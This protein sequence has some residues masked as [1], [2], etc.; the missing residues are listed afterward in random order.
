MPFKSPKF[1]FYLWLTLA[2]KLLIIGLSLLSLLSFFALQ[3]LLPRGDEVVVYANGTEKLRLSLAQ[4]RTVT[5]QG[6]R[7]ATVIRIQ[8]GEARVIR[9]ACHHQICV[10]TAP[11]RRSG[12]IIVCIPNQ[13]LV[14]IEGEKPR[15]P[16]DVITE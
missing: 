11:I 4:S 2:D 14:R 8:A 12:Q 3:S 5:I 10:H 16:L 13:I 6:V 9:S 7:G 1:E 15:L